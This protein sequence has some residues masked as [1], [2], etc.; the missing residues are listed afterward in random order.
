MR[1]FLIADDHFV[2]RT[3]LKY[4]IKEEF[5][6]AE[7]DECRDGDSAW[8][9]IQARQY[10]LAIL[11]VSMPFTDFLNLLENIFDQQPDQKILILTMCSE[12]IY[13]KKYLSLNPGVK[14]FINKEADQSEIRKAIVSILNN[15]RYLSPRMQGILMQETIDEEVHNPFGPLS[16]KELEIM[17]HLVGGKKVR[18]IA[19]I[20][21]VHSLTIWI[22]KAK[23]MLKLGVSNVL[24]LS[25]L[26]Q[27]FK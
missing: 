18:E 17:N 3:G 5:T 22:H 2:V 12:G 19:L 26:V 25:N 15:K 24:E 1:R 14:G 8:K 4:L 11:D 7:I 20:L 9:K 13:A 16:I 6:H 23:L 10:D 21:S 27:R